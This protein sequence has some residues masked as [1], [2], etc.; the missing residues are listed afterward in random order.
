MNY[1]QQWI[2]L[3]EQLHYDT[4]YVFCNLID[5]ALI[6]HINFDKKTEPLL[7]FIIYDVDDKQLLIFDNTN[8]FSFDEIK[9]LANFYQTNNE[10]YHAYFRSLLKLGDSFEFINQN[11]SEENGYYFLVNKVNNE[12]N[13]DDLRQTERGEYYYRTKF[14]NG[15]LIRIK[16]LKKHYELEE[17]KVI[18]NRLK[19]IYQKFINTNKLNIFV[20]YKKNHGFYDLATPIIAPISSFANAKALPKTK[21]PELAILKNDQTRIIIDHTINWNNKN[22]YIK[23][24]IGLLKKPDF[25]KAGLYLYAN[26]KLIKGINSYQ[27]YRPE[28]VFGDVHHLNNKYIFGELELSNMD[29]SISNDS[30]VYDSK[31]EK[32][33]LKFL[34]DTIGD[35]KYLNDDKLSGVIKHTNEINLEEP[36]DQKEDNN[37]KEVEQKTTEQE[38]KQEVNDDQLEDINQEAD[39]KYVVAIND[40]KAIIEFSEQANQLF[41]TS[42]DAIT[43]QII[44]KVD[45]NL[46][47]VKTLLKDK[48]TKR[49]FIKLVASLAYARQ[50]AITNNNSL[51][52]YFDLINKLMAKKSDNSK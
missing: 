13:L 18:A 47:I 21:K 11:A 12:L 3:A 20:L 25:K 43:D 49:S 10:Q 28:M 46:D 45:V 39:N 30:F 2:R 34:I 41:S 36:T 48:T 38:N 37:K 26:N 6:N 7:F 42:F 15:T 8:G 51:E 4:G 5:P 52:E 14:N 40:T 23:G 19:L 9:N 31:F 33:L 22:I 16:N 24:Y 44:I 17:F 1:Q 35:E 27:R 50:T 29:I 32:Q